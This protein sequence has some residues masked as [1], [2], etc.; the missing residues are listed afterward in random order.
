[1]GVIEAVSDLAERLKSICAKGVADVAESRREWHER[2]DEELPVAASVLCVTDGRLDMFVDFIL[3]PL[4]PMSDHQK[5]EVIVAEL[6]ELGIAHHWASF[7][8]WR[9]RIF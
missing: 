2:A 5:V 1:V 3:D 7:V 8:A 6:T 4:R 9:F